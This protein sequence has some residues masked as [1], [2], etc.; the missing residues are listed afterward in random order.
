MVGLA[1]VT[2]TTDITVDGHTLWVRP[3]ITKCGRY[4]QFLTSRDVRVA[5]VV[6]KDGALVAVF[7][8][9]APNAER[10]IVTGLC[11]CGLGGAA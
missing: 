1:E 10:L 3:G 2:T 6:E 8:P 9:V 7:E 5:I 4:W 11:A